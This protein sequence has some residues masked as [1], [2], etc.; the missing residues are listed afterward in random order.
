LT[1]ISDEKLR[2]II[3]RLENILAMFIMAIRK[4]LHHPIEW[5]Y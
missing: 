5:G 1:V 2:G 4:S 3:M